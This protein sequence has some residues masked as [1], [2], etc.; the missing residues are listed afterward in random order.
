MRRTV[1]F[2]AGIALLACSGETTA[3]ETTVAARAGI[4]LDRGQSAEHRDLATLRAATAKFHRFSLADDAGYTLLFMNMCMED[5]SGQNRG[6]M[7]SHYVNTGILFDDDLDVAAPEAL[8]Y[9]HGPNGERRL[10]AVEYVIPEAFWTSATPP[11][12]FG[13]EFT[14][15][16]FGLWALHV[17]VWKHNPTGMYEDFNP[18]VSCENAPVVSTAAHH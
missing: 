2:L 14:L 16:A 9:E 1:H 3:P 17:W 13:Q 10:V 5:V 15:N 7:G 4:E 6:G 11:M 12:L 8:L 18:R